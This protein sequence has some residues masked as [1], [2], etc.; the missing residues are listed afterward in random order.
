MLIRAP[1]K[2]QYRKHTIKCTEAVD[3]K[4]GYKT[5]KNILKSS[6]LQRLLSSFMYV[7]VPKS[8]VYMRIFGVNPSKYPYPPSHII[9]VLKPVA[10]K[11]SKISHRPHSSGMAVL[12]NSQ[13]HYLKSEV[14]PR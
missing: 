8:H 11:H 13:S 12:A 9:L 4:H 7:P 14:H 6:T 1:P 2:Y 10:R 3:K 5:S